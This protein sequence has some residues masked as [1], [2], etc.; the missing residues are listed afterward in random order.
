MLYY[1]S[2]INDFKIEYKLDLKGF[3]ISNDKYTSST[4]VPN[5]NNVSVDTNYY[6]ENGING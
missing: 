4:T 2:S 5:S 6:K 3:S 1:T